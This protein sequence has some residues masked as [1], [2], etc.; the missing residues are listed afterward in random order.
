MDD[1]VD[2]FEERMAG[3]LTEMHKAGIAPEV[4]LMDLIADDN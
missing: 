4:T 1:F 3:N 2:G